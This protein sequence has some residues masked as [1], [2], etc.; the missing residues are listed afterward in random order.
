MPD[1]DRIIRLRTVLARTGLSR[2]TLYRKI[3]LGTFPA[4][5]PHLRPWRRLARIRDRPLG[6]R[7]GR[8]A[9]G[10]GG[11]VTEWARVASRSEI[12]VQFVFVDLGGASLRVDDQRLG[13]FPF[14]RGVDHIS[15]AL[16]HDLPLGK[17]AVHIVDSRDPVPRRVA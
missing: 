14:H 13:G 15:P 8:M 1:A 10:K 16:K 5:A 12:V 4:Q 2:S 9:A 11:A 6:R 7:S 17:V 3:A